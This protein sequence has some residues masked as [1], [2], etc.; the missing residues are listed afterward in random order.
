MNARA[1]KDKVHVQDGLC[2]ACAVHVKQVHHSDF[3]EIRSE[4][5]ST[6]EGVSHLAQQLRLAR[7]GCRTAWHREVIDQAIADVTDFLEAIIAEEQ[8]ELERD[9]DRPR[10]RCAPR[11][12]SR[13]E[14]AATRPGRG[15][16]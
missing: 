8:R 11:G 16:H 5:G 2:A 6:V 14:P 12:S 15:H 13:H 3:P 1:K 9:R 10:C 4:A 7:E